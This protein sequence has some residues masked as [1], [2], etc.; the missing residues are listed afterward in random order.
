[1]DIYALG[2][3]LFELCNEFNTLH[4]RMDNIKKLKLGEVDKSI[5][6][7]FDL[8]IDLV[9]MM[10][11]KDPDQRPSTMEIFGSKEYKALKQLNI[12]N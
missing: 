5:R 12:V 2:I 3:I 1:M 4:E 11:R 7:K 6:Y 10:I 9:L 8:E